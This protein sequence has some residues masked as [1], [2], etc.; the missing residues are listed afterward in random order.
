VVKLVDFSKYQAKKIEESK[1]VRE[2]III[3]DEKITPGKKTKIPKKPR[4]K[5][6]TDRDMTKT[7]LLEAIHSLGKESIV[8]ITVSKLR[9]TLEDFKLYGKRKELM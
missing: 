9:A 3:P 1:T 8:N 2:E 5:P 6:L 4:K 7:Q